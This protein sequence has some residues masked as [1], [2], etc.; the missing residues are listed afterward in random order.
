L[1]IAFYELR[2]K[3]P[4][5]VKVFVFVISMPVSE[6]VCKTLEHSKDGSVEEVGT[7]DK[8]VFIQLN[9]PPSSYKEGF[10]KQ[11]CHQCMVLLILTTS[12]IMQEVS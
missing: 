4:T 7:N 11:L 9:G 10:L 1:K 2:E 6:A 12:E 8:R 5:F 3:L